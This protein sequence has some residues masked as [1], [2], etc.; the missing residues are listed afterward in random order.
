[1]RALKFHNS[2]FSRKHRFLLFL[3]PNRADTYSR[4]SHCPSISPA[5]ASGKDNRMPWTIG[6]GYPLY[7]IVE[8][9]VSMEI[10]TNIIFLLNML[11]TLINHF[12]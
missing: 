12:F 4:L 2:L 1:M 3:C 11:K 8:R 6:S 7:L 5:A 9:K 10:L